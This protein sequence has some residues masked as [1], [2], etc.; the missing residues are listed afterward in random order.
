MLSF[1][2]FSDG[3]KDPFLKLAVNPIFFIDLI[4]IACR[5][6]SYKHASIVV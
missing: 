2:V 5:A 4:L 6:G 3:F 1:V